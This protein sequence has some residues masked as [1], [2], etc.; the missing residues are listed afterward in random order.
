M[1]KFAVFSGI[2]QATFEENGD[3]YG[4]KGGKGSGIGDWGSEEERLKVGGR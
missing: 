4:K 3:F 2:L 1:A